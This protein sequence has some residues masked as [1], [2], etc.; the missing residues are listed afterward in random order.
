MQVL[1]SAVSAVRLGFW[2]VVIGFALGIAVG[3]RAA[4]SDV[5]QLPPPLPRD[6]LS[7]PGQVGPEPAVTVAAVAP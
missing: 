3:Y 4:S 6:V 1:M 5:A 2:L 7:A